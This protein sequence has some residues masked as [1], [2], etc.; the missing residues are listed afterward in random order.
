MKK[1]AIT[2]FSFCLAFTISGQEVKSPKPPLPPKTPIDV[3]IAPAPPAPP[4]DPTFPNKAGSFPLPPEVPALPLSPTSDLSVASL[5]EEAP[6]ALYDEYID[7][8]LR[9]F[10][11]R[12]PSVR[13]LNWT[14]NAV[15]IKLKNGKEE[16]YL[17]HDKKSM[18]EAEEKYGEFPL[19]PPPPPKVIAPPPPPK[20]KI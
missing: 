4:E 17:L 11:K 12:N 20:S 6:G 18:N 9:T 3:A 2:V 1:I 16:R 13:S 19:A 10:L 14:E 15:I 8:D 5:I 7:D